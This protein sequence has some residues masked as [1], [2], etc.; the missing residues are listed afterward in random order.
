MK[1]ILTFF[2]RDTD[3]ETPSA[4]K[5]RF[6]FKNN[7]PFWKGSDGI[8]HTLASFI[9]G[10]G[11]ELSIFEDYVMTTS[12]STWNTY[13]GLQ[14]P[15]NKE[16]T[17]LVIAFSFLRMSTT[18]YDARMRIAKN[19]SDV[20]NYMSEELKDSNNSQKTP[21]IIIKKIELSEG[22][23]LDLD[24]ATE[25]TNGTLTIKE[26]SLILWRIS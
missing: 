7:M 15:A 24:F 14:V 13:A 5:I 22:D 25:N 23:Y 18:S 9:F 21:R 1:S 4:G 26:G 20:G 17:Y 11:I 6:W 10:L 19:G 2:N 12:G 16:G 8:L 3:P